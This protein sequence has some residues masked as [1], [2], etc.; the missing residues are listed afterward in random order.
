MS[1]LIIK[2]IKSNNGKVLPVVLLDSQADVMEFE[3]KEEADKM[4][5]MLNINSDSGHI[6][7][8]KKIGEKE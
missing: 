5:T 7:R 4:A 8:T 2:E 6:Y 3:D 1:Y